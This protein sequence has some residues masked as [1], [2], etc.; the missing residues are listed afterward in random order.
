[1]IDSIQFHHIVLIWVFDA[2]DE[3]KVKKVEIL[4]LDSLKCLYFTFN[5]EGYTRWVE[6]L[7][8]PLLTEQ[9]RELFSKGHEQL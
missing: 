7:G 9:A 8:R 4:Y 5:V 1:V 3:K 2:I 6:S